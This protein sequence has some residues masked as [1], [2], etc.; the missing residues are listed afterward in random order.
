ME[1]KCGPYGPPDRFEVVVIAASFG[2]V[3]A[4]KDL[5]SC[6]PPFLPVPVL[7][8]Q[9]LSPTYRSQL[10]QVLS[11]VGPLPVRFAQDGESPEPGTVY[12][13][14]PDRHMVVRAGRLCL[15]E[16]PR[17]NSTR[18]AA[19]PTLE[20]VAREYGPG[21]IGVILTGAGAD[22]A[23]GIAELRRRGGRILVQELEEAQ[24]PSMPSA[25]LS[26]GC[27]ELALPL[28]AI[29]HALAAWTLHPESSRLFRVP[30]PPWAASPRRQAG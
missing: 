26:T 18:P 22:G 25:A 19:D 14:P 20:S 8:V 21:A 13:A 16:T 12:L 2:G 5:L 15:E 9:H 10:D 28:R 24:V 7:V 11:R 4:L 30:L 3:P 29:A 1:R 6:L 27:V 23:A 17:R